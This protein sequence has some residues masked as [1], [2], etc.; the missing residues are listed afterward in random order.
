LTFLAKIR[1]SNNPQ[2]NKTNASPM[3]SRYRSS[4]NAKSAT[5]SASVA[6]IGGKP[7]IQSSPDVN[8]D[9][10]MGKAVGSDLSSSASS[11]TTAT[12]SNEPASEP[13]SRDRQFRLHM[14]QNAHYRLHQRIFATPDSPDA[15][16]SLLEELETLSAEYKALKLFDEK[17]GVEEGEGG[18][19]PSA[20]RST[21]INFQPV[22]VTNFNRRRPF[23]QERELTG[24]RQ[25]SNNPIVAQP[26]VV[27]SM[28][29][30]RMW[31]ALHSK[32]QELQECEDSPN[33]LLEMV[34][35]ANSNKLR[36][37]EARE[38]PVE[39]I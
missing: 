36:M 12:N 8:L 28:K 19:V 6:A 18:N 15:I 35:K 22:R 10:S 39:E 26:Q 31:L 29:L 23:L 4:G 25:S 13:K 27:E 11:L 20:F 21:S 33:E 2:E 16:Q 37:K 9:G 7:V 17:K 14:L 34:V 3:L 24:P 1:Q 38:Q 5:V 32:I 30:K